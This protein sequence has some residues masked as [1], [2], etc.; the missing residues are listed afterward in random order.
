MPA[1]PYDV[2][3]H[4]KETICSYIETAYKVSNRLVF[5]ERSERL[6]G[7]AVV[8]QQPFLEST[9]AFPGTE[10]LKD[11]VSRLPSVPQQLA[12]LAAFGMPVKNYPLYTHQV[13][14]LERVFIDNKHLLVT[15]GTGSGKTETF[16]LVALA[17]I[18]REA[19]SWPFPKGNPQPGTYNSAQQIWLH[20][21][22]HENAKRKAAVRAIVLYPM[23]A[24]VNDQLND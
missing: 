15:T 20:G 9:P 2:F 3:S 17:S 14:G 23:N 19:L 4:L 13:D 16:L 7:T 5:A 1:S 11:I 12:D 21:R 10:F 22:R 18:L 24:L 6:R 8:A